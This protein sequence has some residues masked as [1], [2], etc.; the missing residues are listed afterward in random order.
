MARLVIRK[1]CTWKKSNYIKCEKYPF[2]N[3][4]QMT[5]YDMCNLQNMKILKHL[6][7]NGFLKSIYGRICLT[8][9]FDLSQLICMYPI[10]RGVTYIYNY[11]NQVSTSFKKFQI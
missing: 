5:S 2:S 7:G 4:V 11:Y 9:K 3:K 1:E 10:T 6:A 8:L